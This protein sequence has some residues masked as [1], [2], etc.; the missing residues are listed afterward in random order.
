MMPVSAPVDVLTGF[1]TWQADSQRCHYEK[2]GLNFGVPHQKF[3]GAGNI[4]LDIIR[5]SCTHSPCIYWR[6]ILKNGNA[7]TVHRGQT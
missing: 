3:K 7:I 4:E 1:G 5:S 6:I 2:P